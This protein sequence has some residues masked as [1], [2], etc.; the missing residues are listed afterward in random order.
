[1]SSFAIKFP[2]IAHIGNRVSH[3]KNRRKHAF[4][5]NLQTV[6][7]VTESGKQRM[8]VPAR[9]LKQLKK[10]GVTNHWKKPE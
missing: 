1:M 3:A 6:T 9:M 2:S 10:S 5:Y 4:K 7:I 8:R